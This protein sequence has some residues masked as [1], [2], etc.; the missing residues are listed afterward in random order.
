MT[1]QT[2]LLHCGGRA[3]AS[4]LLA[5]AFAT[6]LTATAG[7]NDAAA[8]S[9]QFEATPYLWATGLDGTLAINNRPQQGLT[10]QQ[11][12]SDLFKI[13]DLAASGS[14]EA[15]NGRWGVLF[16]AVYFKVSDTA[17]VT[18]PLGFVTLAA[19]G[20]VTQQM[21]SLL[22]SYRVSD[23][24]SQVDLF[25]GLRYVSVHGMWTCRRRCRNWRWRAA[26][27]GRRN[28]GSI[29]SSVRVSSIL[30]ANAGR[31]SAMPKSAALASAPT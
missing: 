4:V 18:G 26:A 12:F 30:L 1:R 7:D 13:L 19:D 16:D 9:W 2:N 25:G 14:F 31:W 11:D 24:P 6:P 21:Y 3:V 10:V 22:A 29:R 27:S 17:A 20:T 15:R 28:T 8:G 23:G 5:G